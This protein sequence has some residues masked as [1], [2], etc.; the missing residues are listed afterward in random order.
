MAR[1]EAA[2]AVADAALEACLPLLGERPTEAAL[3][4]ELDSAMR[5]L[6]AEG[7]A[8]ETIVAAGPNSA[9]PHH[10]PGP[11]VVAEGDLVV[12]DFGA[13][14]DGYRSD[15]TRTVCVGDAESPPSACSTRWS[16]RPRPPAGPPS[17]PTW[18]PRTSTPPPAG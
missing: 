17:S 8:F 16:G 15:M 2:A 3:A 6:G 12:L 5:R 14:V 10:R 4:L 9:R 11:A 13:T 18:R 7:A 1:M